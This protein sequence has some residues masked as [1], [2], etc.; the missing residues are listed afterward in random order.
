MAGS[1]QPIEKDW[2]VVLW[3][4][5]CILPRLEF[6]VL[7]ACSCALGW[8]GLSKK[9]KKQATKCWLDQLWVMV[10]M[11]T[12]PHRL[13]GLNTWSLVGGAG[14]RGCGMWYL[15]IAR[16]SGGFWL[17]PSSLST[18]FSLGSIYLSECSSC[19]RDCLCL[20]SFSSCFILRSPP[21][22]YLLWT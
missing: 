12:A 20:N 5:L 6:P 15:F 7:I 1:N 18:C 9:K 3:A 4:Q 17:V 14:F 19:T 16:I 21:K 22:M 10:W 13:V 8:S 2:A 11:W